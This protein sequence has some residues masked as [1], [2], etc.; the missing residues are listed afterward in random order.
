VVGDGDAEV[1]QEAVH[2]GGV[3]DLV[4]HD[5]GDDVLFLHAR[6]PHDPRD[7]PV[8]AGKLRVGLHRHEVDKALP[9]LFGHLGR[10]LDPITAV[11]LGEALAGGD[12]HSR[13]IRP[14][15]RRR[16]PAL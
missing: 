10:R 13:M 6:G 9:V 14:S 8:P 16:I 2:H 3:S 15:A 11:D 1:G 5:L 7:V 4:L 12:A